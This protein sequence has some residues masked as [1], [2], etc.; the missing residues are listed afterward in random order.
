[1]IEEEM[2]GLGSR[3]KEVSGEQGERSK[4]FINIMEMVQ[5]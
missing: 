3:K 4:R 1:V 5:F 2:M